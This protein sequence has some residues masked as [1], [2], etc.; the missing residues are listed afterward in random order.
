MDRV[1]VTSRTDLQSRE[2]GTG[3]FVNGFLETKALLTS[4]QDSV[5]LGTV[6]TD[7]DIRPPI[8]E[9]RKKNWSRKSTSIER[10]TDRWIFKNQKIQSVTWDSAWGGNWYHHKKRDIS[11]C[12]SCSSKQDRGRTFT[13][14]F[15][16]RRP[17]TPRDV[18]RIDFYNDKKPS[19][20][21]I[22]LKNRRLQRQRMLN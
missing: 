11:E 10:I 20:K 2:H 18:S 7:A 12:Y 3:G 22:E 4:T 15:R 5:E 16:Q 8:C 19:S 9:T 17:R 13:Y 21:R 6:G 14:C 1:S